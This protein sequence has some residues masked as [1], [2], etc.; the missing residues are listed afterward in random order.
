M[1]T[2]IT[3]GNKEITLENNGAWLIEYRNQFGRD[4][5]PAIMPLITTI[6]ETISTV[7]SESASGTANVSEK[8]LAETI[9]GRAME[10]LMPLYSAELTEFAI[11][12]TWAMNKAAT[13]QIEPPEKWVRQFET[14]YLDEIIPTV[15]DLII[16]G[17]FSENFQKRLDAL[18]LRWTDQPSDLT[19]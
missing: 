13:P 6:V 11:Y 16:K 12:I 1:Q 4:I 8:E 15:F 18:K 17:M 10:I 7:I 2:I 19:T 14:F 3:I 9:N 5:M